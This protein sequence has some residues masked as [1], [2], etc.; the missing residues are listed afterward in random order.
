MISLFMR[1]KDLKIKKKQAGAEL[2]QAQA[3][4]SKLELFLIRQTL[5]FISH[6]EIAFESVIAVSRAWKVVY[7]PGNTGENFLAKRMIFA[8]RNCKQKNIFH[9]LNYQT[10]TKLTQK[11]IFSSFFD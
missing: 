8:D 10:W 6:Y 9:D 11:H 5:W 3:S 4:L 1:C 2:S 7:L